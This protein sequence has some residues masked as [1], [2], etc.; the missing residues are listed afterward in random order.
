[1]ATEFVRQE[2]AYDQSVKVNTASQSKSKGIVL[3]EGDSG[4][5]A[6]LAHAVSENE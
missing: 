6:S 4:Q 2:G 5:G 1:M 3:G